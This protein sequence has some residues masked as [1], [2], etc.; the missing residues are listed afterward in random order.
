MNASRK[1]HVQSLLDGLKQVHNQVMRDVE[2]AKREHIFIFGP[3][4]FDQFNIEPFLP[5]K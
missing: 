1:F 2:P 5:G 4:A 3:L